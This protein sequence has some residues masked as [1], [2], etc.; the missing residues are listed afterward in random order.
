MPDRIETEGGRAQNRPD[1]PDREQVFEQGQLETHQQVMEEAAALA[2]ARPGAR[3]GPRP[4]AST[5]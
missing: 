3:P 1:Q 5:S 4:R 2:R